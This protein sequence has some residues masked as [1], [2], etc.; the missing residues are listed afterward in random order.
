MAANGVP[1]HE[2]HMRTTGDQRKDCVIKDELFKEHIEGKYFVYAILDDR[3]QMT[4]YWVD[5]GY[6]DRL[7]TIG[8]PSHEF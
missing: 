7:F 2:L 8:N 4:R 6:M 5:K 1:Y 3:N